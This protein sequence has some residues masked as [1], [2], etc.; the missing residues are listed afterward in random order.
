MIGK[1]LSLKPQ[2]L[3]PFAAQ[4]YLPVRAIFLSESMHQLDRHQSHGSFDFAAHVSFSAQ[5]SKV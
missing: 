2:F 4:C 3:T 5:G 1:F